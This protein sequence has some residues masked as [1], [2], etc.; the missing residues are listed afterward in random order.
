MPAQQKPLADQIDHAQAERAQADPTET[1]PAS[2]TAGVAVANRPKTV[3]QELEAARPAIEAALPRGFPGG[4]DRFERIVLTA[5]RLSPG[6]ARC[7]PVSILGAALQAAQL[8]LTPGALGECWLIPYRN[9]DTGLEEASFQL[10]W[11]GLVALASRSGIRITGAAVHEADQF[12]YELGLEPRLTHRPAGGDR[13]APVYWY[14]IAR[15]ANTG[16][17]VDFAVID[18]EAV[19]KRRKASKVPNSPAWREWYSEMALGKAARELARF[20]PMTVEMANAI[21]SDGLVRRE[22]TGEA[23]EH[24]ADYIDVDEVE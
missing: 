9:K 19:E 23:D 6:L 10:G 13:G 21:A 7:T 5:V 4:R 12:D 16:A 22:L 15:D 20:L 24:V 2:S 8:G 17:L 1:A 3:R 14:A 11:K 18:R